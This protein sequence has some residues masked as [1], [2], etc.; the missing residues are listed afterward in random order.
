MIESSKRKKKSNWSIRKSRRNVNWNNMNSL[1]KSLILT[2]T[3]SNKNIKEKIFDLHKNITVKCSPGPNIKKETLKVKSNSKN[4]NSK[5][6]ILSSHLS[7]P[8]AKK[9]SETRNSKE[10]CQS[11]NVSPNKKKQ[12]KILIAHLSP[13]S[14]KAISTKK[15]HTINRHYDY[16]FISIKNNS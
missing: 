15:C 1:R 14:T 9:Y 10:L 2:W 3:S 8:K 11:M 13:K 7:T 6:K 4:K 5:V 12:K 16:H